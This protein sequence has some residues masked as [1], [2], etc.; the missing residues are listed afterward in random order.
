MKANSWLYH[1]YM[2]QSRLQYSL[3]YGGQSPTALAAFYPQT[4][5]GGHQGPKLQNVFTLKWSQIIAVRF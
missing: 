2:V 3:A 5:F 4:A 1:Y